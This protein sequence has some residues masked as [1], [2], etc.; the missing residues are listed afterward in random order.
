M[1][2]WKPFPELTSIAAYLRHLILKFHRMVFDSGM[3]T[4]KNV[5][6]KLTDLQSIDKWMWIILNI[7][8][9]HGNVWKSVTKLRAWNF[10]IF[11]IL[12]RNCWKNSRWSV[13][14][15]KAQAGRVLVKL[16][17]FGVIKNNLALNY[18]KQKFCFSE[19]LTSKTQAIAGM[20]VVPC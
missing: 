7:W 6:S 4:T 13:N 12:M 14:M 18:C 2:M 5:W 3:F 11:S 1:Q 19:I 8:I 10:L 17:N 20:C 16:Y 15:L 9:S